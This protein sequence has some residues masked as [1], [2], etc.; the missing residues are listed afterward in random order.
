VGA[1]RWRY[2]TN[3]MIQHADRY[4]FSVDFRIRLPLNFLSWGVFVWMI[5]RFW[6]IKPIA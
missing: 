1:R 6:P 4:R 5:P 2:Q 3:A